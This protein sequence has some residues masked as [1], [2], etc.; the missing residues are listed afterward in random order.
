[1]DW[2]VDFLL[3]FYGPVPYLIIFSILMA[4]GLGLPIPEDITLFAAGLCCY[5]GLT[6][7]GWMISICLV[8][9][10]LGDSLI[11]WLGAH[12]GKRLTQH[13]FF[14][15]ILPENQLAQVQKKFHQGGNRLI[16]IARFMPGLRAPIFF[17]AGALHLPFRVFFFYDG[18][19]AFLSVPAIVW[20]VYAFGDELESVVR[21]IQHFEHGI[22]LGGFGLLGWM[23]WKVFQKKRAKRQASSPL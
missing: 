10:L 21:W 12:S 9:V 3:N 5:Y 11:F 17:T 4:C 6:E 18:S 20:A 16:F 8:G 22:A 23:A 7:L 1:M 15:K 14:Q 2:I 13:W 19:A